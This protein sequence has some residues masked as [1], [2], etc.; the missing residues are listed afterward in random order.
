MVPIDIHWQQLLWNCYHHGRVVKKDDSEIKELMGNYVFLDRPQDLQFPLN[1][2]VNEINKFFD[3]LK[4]GFYDLPNYPLKG[5]ALF[6]YVNSWNDMDKIY[7][8][9]VSREDLGLKGKP[10]VYTYPERLLHK[11]TVG[12]PNPDFED[13]GFFI[14]QFDIIWSR[15][16]EN[17]GSNRAVATLYQPGMDYLQKDIPCLNWLQA[18]VR[19]NNLELHCMFRSNDLYGAWPSNMYLLT[20]LGLWMAEELNQDK[21]IKEN[22]LFNGIHYH[23]SSLHIYKTDLPAV[24][25]IL[26]EGK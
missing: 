4:K 26:G 21:N 15:L 22:I 6:N 25:N 23:S 11:F 20:A 8:D 2:E 16:H 18:T 13:K 10:F 17:L 3:G 9:E 19:N 12:A 14:N 7:L 5:E 1:I 24:E